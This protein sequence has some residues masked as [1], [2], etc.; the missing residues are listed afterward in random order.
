[1]LNGLA[2][3]RDRALSSVHALLCFQC[4]VRFSTVRSTFFFRSGLLSLSGSKP[5]RLALSLWRAARCFSL[6]GKAIVHHM[7][8]P[9]KSVTFHNFPSPIYSGLPISR[10]FL[11]SP[12]FFALSEKFHV[13]P[14]FASFKSL[15]AVLP[16]FSKIVGLF[17]AMF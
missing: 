7:G 9:V 3:S 16:S 11:C 8:I 15:F 5:P 14:C 1:M 12:I 6:T 17:L 2:R 13:L 10:N 4:T